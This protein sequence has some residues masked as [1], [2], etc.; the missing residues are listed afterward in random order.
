MS[1]YGFNDSVHNVE[2]LDKIFDLLEGKYEVKT[3]G[4]YT[5][6]I[7]EYELLQDKEIRHLAS[8]LTKSFYQYKS[9]KLQWTGRRIIVVNKKEYENIE[10]K[11]EIDLKKKAQ[12]KKQKL[13]KKKE[14]EQADRGIYGIY[15]DGQLVYIGKTEVSF[16]ERFEQHREA[17]Q[18]E[19]PVQYLH[20]RLKQWKA[21]DKRIHLKCLINIKE[22]QT[23]REL[24]STDIKSMELALIALYQ[25]I[26]NVEGVSK[27]YQYYRK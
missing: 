4:Y 23:D 16:A 12:E 27:P 18:A 5:Y 9:T 7:I 21:E 14:R 11:Y 1:K 6:L 10:K 19:E 17:M 8:Q 3:L 2:C 15:V 22:L 24:T 20:K 13:Q 26:C 25:P